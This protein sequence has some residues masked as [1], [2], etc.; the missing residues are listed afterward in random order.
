MAR[1]LA[2]IPVF[3]DDD[4]LFA[5]NVTGTPMGSHIYPELMPD[6]YTSEMVDW[7]ELCGRG[8]GRSSS[9]RRTWHC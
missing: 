3:I 9:H 2:E 6:Y 8:R 7:D 1:T 5:G 4:D